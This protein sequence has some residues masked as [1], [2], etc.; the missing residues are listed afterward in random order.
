MDRSDNQDNIY[1]ALVID[2]GPIIRLQTASS[3]SELWKRATHFYT[4]P[5][6][7]A[8]IRDAKARQHLQT[9]PFELKT[10]EPSP[11][12]IQAVVD[13]A[14]KTG[15]YPSLSS[16]DLQ[17]L[18][19]VYELEKEGC[20]DISHIRKTPKRMI[21][22]GKLETLGSGNATELKSGMTGSGEYTDEDADSS[23]DDGDDDDEDS[24]SEDSSMKDGKGQVPVDHPQQ[25]EDK[26]K[27]FSW[28]KVVSPDAADVPENGAP[29]RPAALTDDSVLN[30]PFGR[31]NLK[32]QFYTER[33]DEGQFSDAEDDPTLPVA[34]SS[35]NEEQQGSNSKIITPLSVEEELQKEFPSLAAAATVPYE[36]SDNEKNN[37]P[38]EKYDEASRIRREAE[39][40]AR[41]E[42][43]LRPI[44]KSGKL[45]NSF[46][47]YGDLMKPKEPKAPMKS[48]S[49][50]PTVMNVKQDNDNDD[51]RLDQGQSRIIGAA[52][53]GQGDDVEDDGEGWITSSKEIHTMK[54]TGI[55]DPLRSLNQSANG[56]SKPGEL[57]P[58]ISQRTA[59][60]TTDFAMVRYFFAIK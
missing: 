37:D 33:S 31:M 39:E 32:E 7:L 13:F 25:Q 10:R 35:V 12:S 24:F 8:E 30:I 11:E 56:V 14:R 19:L 29:E 43:A 9:L 23:D 45:Y 59:C 52:F 21:G 20:G 15:D 50:L 4:V 55:L 44:S 22:L 40:R 26:P 53:G 57:G 17:V 42:A 60:A 54:A 48:T 46:R 38:N 2:S 28:A 1:H 5:A 36:D 58:P 3:T 27:T 41:K 6:V 51:K 34:C 47:K 49:P 16:V 18:G